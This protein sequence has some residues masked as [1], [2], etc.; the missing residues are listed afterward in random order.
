MA[1]IEEIKTRV[2]SDFVSELGNDFEQSEVNAT[3]DVFAGIS[4]LLELKIDQLSRSIIPNPN[5]PLE[6][7]EIYAGV[8]NVP[9]R[10][11][12][13]SRGQVVV[14]SNRNMVLNSGTRFKS[15]KDKIYKSEQDANL[16]PG[17]NLVSLISEDKGQDTIVTIGSLSLVVSVEGVNSECPIAGSGILGGRDEGTK[18][19]LYRDYVR[20]VQSKAQVGDDDDWNL[21]VNEPNFV[22]KGFHFPLW[23]GPGYIGVTFVV[24]DEFGEITHGSVENKRIFFDYIESKRIVG[25]SIV[26]ANIYIKNINIVITSPHNVLNKMDLDKELRQYF[27]ERMIPGGAFIPDGQTSE[28]KK[29]EITNLV[30][31]VTNIFDFTLTLVPDVVLPER[32]EVFNYG[33]VKWN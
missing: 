31:L 32:G 25:P 11:S 18:A 27:I 26:E 6:I 30:I 15:A 19:E 8:Y 3:A 20:T 10:T 23:A 29:A 28:L 22:F 2:R 9:K 16:I 13:Y 17:N 33:G 1:S 14:I 24:L 21:W 4:Y 5:M 12:D 7:L